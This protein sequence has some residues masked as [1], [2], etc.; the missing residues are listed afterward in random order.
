MAA[1]SP[2]IEPLTRLLGPHDTQ[3]GLHYLIYS[4]LLASVIFPAYRFV[5]NDYKSFLSLGPGGTPSTFIGYLRITFLRLFTL[6]DP[7]TPP[8]IIPAIHLSTGYLSYLPNRTG[9]RPRVAGIAPHRQTTQKACLKLSEAL[10]SSLK[11]LVA[12]NSTLLYSG[13]SCFE[14]HNLAIFYSPQ[15]NRPQESDLQTAACQITSST[16]FSGLS[17]PLSPSINPTCGS[18]PEI[19]HMHTTDSSMHLTLHPSDAALVIANGWGERHPLAGQGFLGLRWVPR[20][21]VMVYAPRDEKDLPILMEIVKAGG[22]WV[23]GCVL[24]GVEKTVN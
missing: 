7:F 6:K 11:R 2:Y 17:L 1:V 3:N 24:N 14:K 15:L 18:P 9:P 5:L 19:A 12:S 4:T 20:G 16:R 8:S 13:I 22:W 21:F 10:T 23:G